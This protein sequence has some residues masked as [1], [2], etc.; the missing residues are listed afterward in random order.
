MGKV[1]G[2][3]WVKEVDYI[4]LSTFVYCENF[5]NLKKQ[6]GCDDYFC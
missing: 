4:I 3:S 6:L 1:D 5:R 2:Q